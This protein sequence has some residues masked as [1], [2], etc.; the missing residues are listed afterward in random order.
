MKGRRSIAVAILVGVLVGCLLQARPARA[1]NSI[2]VTGGSEACGQGA[3]YEVSFWGTYTADSNP[4]PWKSPAVKGGCI[5][6]TYGGVYP[7]G[8]YGDAQLD[9]AGGASILFNMPAYFPRGYF[10]GWFVWFDL[11]YYDEYG[12]FFVVVSSIEYFIPCP[13]SCFAAGTPVLTPGGSKAIEQLR[14]GDL[15]LSSPERK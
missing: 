11:G 12:T 10:R 14:A 7:P 5:T 15:V 13:M 1:T 6:A 4:F 9:G 3:G 8:K 2:T